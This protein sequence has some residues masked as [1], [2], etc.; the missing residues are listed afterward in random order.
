VCSQNS[1][2]WKDADGHGISNADSPTRD[3]NGEVLF[4][5]P[6]EE[7]QPFEEFVDF[8]SQQEL[9]REKDVKEV[10]YAQTRDSPHSLYPSY[11]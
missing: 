5:K 6:W 11:F 2:E 8:V 7:Q 3:E 4:I 1:E 10:R 9:C